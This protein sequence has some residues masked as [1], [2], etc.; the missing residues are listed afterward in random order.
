MLAC[1]HFSL[2]YKRGRDMCEIGFKRFHQVLLFRLLC[3][4]KPLLR[5]QALVQWLVLSQLAIGLLALPAIG[6]EMTFRRVTIDQASGCA[7][8]CLQVIVAEGEIVDKSAQALVDF[9]KQTQINPGLRRV[10]FL[11]SQGGRVV[12]SMELGQVFRRLDLDVVVM[13]ALPNGKGNVE[14]YAGQCYSACVYAL[15]GGVSRYVPSPSLVGLHRMFIMDYQADPDDRSAQQVKKIYADPK[16]IAS[17]KHYVRKMGVSA[18]LV[19]RAESSR[20]DQLQILT[21]AELRSFGLAKT[22]L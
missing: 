19:T 8:Q 11:H 1:A 2:A 17:L 15:A 7:N 4:R 14:M 12:A 5:A 18:D 20:T 13:R 16:L 10:V 3:S 21:P 22:K 9:L 6:A